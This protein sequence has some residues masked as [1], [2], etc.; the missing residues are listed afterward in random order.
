MLRL[1][2]VV[3]GSV[4]PVALIVI[5]TGMAGISTVRAEVTQAVRDACTPDAMQFCSDFV[6]DVPKVTACMQR[7]YRQLS[8]DCRVA[9]A[10]EHRHYRH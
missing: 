7:H 6:P 2:H 9:M 4:L 1:V 3:C 10:N 5:G 8:R